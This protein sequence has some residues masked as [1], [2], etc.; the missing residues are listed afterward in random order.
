VENHNDFDPVQFGRQARALIRSIFFKNLAASPSF[1]RFCGDTL[2]SMIANSNQSNNLTKNSFIFRG[3]DPMPSNKPKAQQSK[4]E[5][6]PALKNV[7]T[8][9]H[10]KV[11]GVQCGGP[12]MRGEQFCYFHQR[13]LRGVKTPPNARLHPIAQIESEESI[14]A[15]LMEVI[16]ALARNHIDLRRADLMLRALS[17]AVRNARRAKFD[18]H[19]SSMVREI[20]D[21]PAPPKPAAPP[22]AALKEKEQ[23]LTDRA[24]KNALAQVQA[25]AL[26][27]IP[28]PATANSEEERQVMRRCSSGETAEAGAPS[29][30]S[31]QGWD[32][33]T[34]R[35][36]S[37]TPPTTIKTG[38]TPL[39][40]K[41]AALTQSAKEVDPTQRKPPARAGSPTTTKIA[42]NQQ[43][44]RT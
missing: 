21:Y 35:T 33:A 9:Q 30:R 26:A 1:A 25:R 13:M 14:Q 36:E 8:C 39:T 28:T 18:I 34:E 15:S 11:T 24:A 41:T 29:L 4:A 2:R 40:M 3:P 27:T 5:Q 6:P 17:I 20:P 32:F 22:A 43:K 23:V 12:A 10:I 7:R 31:V 37:I 16:N 38:Q 19:D 44:T 42:V